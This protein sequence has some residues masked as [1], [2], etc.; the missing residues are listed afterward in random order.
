MNNYFFRVHSIA[1]NIPRII[2]K[3]VETLIIIKEYY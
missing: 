3:N 1:I 2:Q